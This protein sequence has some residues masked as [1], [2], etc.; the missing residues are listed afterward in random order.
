MKVIIMSATIDAATYA[1]LF[2]LVDHFGPDAQPNAVLLRH[3]DVQMPKIIMMRSKDI[4]I[5]T[6]APLCGVGPNLHLVYLFIA[7]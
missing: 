1:C 3:R 5:E 2:D 4:H 7:Y 6:P